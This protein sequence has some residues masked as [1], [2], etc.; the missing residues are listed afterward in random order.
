MFKQRHNIQHIKHNITKHTHSTKKKETQFSTHNKKAILKHKIRNTCKRTI[1]KTQSLKQT[2]P[3]LNKHNI[4]HT[5]RKHA[6]LKRTS[7][8]QTQYTK[9]TILE[10]II[11][12]SNRNERHLNKHTVLNTHKTILF[13]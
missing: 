11:R 1:L 10:N 5:I 4:K 7:Q 9:T 8:Q 6:I 12:Q 2:K 3:L 13:F